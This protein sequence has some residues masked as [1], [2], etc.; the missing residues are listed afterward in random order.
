MRAPDRRP[1]RASCCG[2]TVGTRAATRSP[3]CYGSGSGGRPETGSSRRQARV[4]EAGLTGREAGDAGGAAR[5]LAELR[6]LYEPYVA[7][8][9][10]H[11]AVTLP[12]WVRQGERPD[13]W[14]TSAWEKPKALPRLGGSQ[15]RDDHF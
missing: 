4:V 15:V 10:R 6:R 8:L 1:R 7:A 11:L 9:A 14:Q 12:P 5:Q 3:S 13:N 2:A